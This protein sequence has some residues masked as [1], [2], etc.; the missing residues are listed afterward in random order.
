VV[1]VVVVGVAE[2][3]GVEGLLEHAATET[4]TIAAVARQTTTPG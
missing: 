4:R 2:T 3:N 1:A